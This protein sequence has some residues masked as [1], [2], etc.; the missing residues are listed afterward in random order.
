MGLFSSNLDRA[1][2]AAIIARFSMKLI[3]SQSLQQ[4][5]STISKL[6]IMIH[7]LLFSVA[8]APNAWSFFTN[9]LAVVTYDV[10]DP[11]PLTVRLF[12][13]YDPRVFADTFSELGYQSRYF[14]INMAVIFYVGIAFA[15]GLLLVPFT[16]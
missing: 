15:I 11:K 7:L 3:L 5:F 8:I 10:I 16:G 4:L 2:K 9:Y 6:Q 14:I 13:L 1:C 12:G